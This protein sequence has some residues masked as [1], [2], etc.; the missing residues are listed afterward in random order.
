[1]GPLTFPTELRTPLL[2]VNGMIVISGR[3]LPKLLPMLD[4]TVMQ[5]KLKHCLVSVFFNSG[6]FTPQGTLSND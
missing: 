6:D 3:Q 5:V 1:M 2:L 4:Y